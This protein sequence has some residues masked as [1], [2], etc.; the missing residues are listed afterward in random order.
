M[1]R[2]GLITKQ[3]MENYHNGKNYWR[4]V[5]VNDD[6]ESLFEDLRFGKKPNRLAHT[7]FLPK[8]TKEELKL[9]AQKDI[10][11]LLTFALPKPDVPE[12]EMKL[13]EPDSKFVQGFGW[14]K[15][16]IIE[17]SSSKTFET[18]VLRNK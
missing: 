10:S 17:N 14:R 16:F 18:E 15:S 11:Y 6:L 12:A 4:G 8:L 2:L 9:V 1:R 5:S 7:Y 3:A 13:S